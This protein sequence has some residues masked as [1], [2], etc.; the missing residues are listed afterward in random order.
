MEAEAAVTHPQPGSGR[1]GL[2]G[3]RELGRRP[4]AASSLSSRRSRTCGPLTLDFSPEN[5][6]DTLLLFQPSALWCRGSCRK[7]HSKRFPTIQLPFM[8]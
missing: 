1:E 6:E 7:P 4:G 8:T 3:P 5:H 2:Q